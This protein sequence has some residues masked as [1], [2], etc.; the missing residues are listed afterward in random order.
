MEL[1]RSKGLL[2]LDDVMDQVCRLKTM[3]EWLAEALNPDMCE[4][5]LWAMGRSIRWIPELQQAWSYPVPN[6]IVGESQR[7][8]ILSFP[9]HVFSNNS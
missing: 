1:Q 8:R 4:L 9:I 6:S 5:G 7:E 2:H 3:F